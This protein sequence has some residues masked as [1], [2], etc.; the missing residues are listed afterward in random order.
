[1]NTWE[2]YEKGGVM[3]VLIS[4]LSVYVLGVVAY[5][6]WQLVQTNALRTRAVR[7]TL[8]EMRAGR[9]AEAYA[10]L[11]ENGSPLAVVL[12]TVVDC[13]MNRAMTDAQRESEVMRVGAVELARMERHMRGLEM[14]SGI[15]PLLGLLGTVIGLIDSFSKLGASGSRVD[16]AMLA[17]GIWE[18]LLATAAGLA[19]AITAFA[20][21]HVFDTLLDGLRATMQ[22]VTTQAMNMP[23]ADGVVLPK[24]TETSPVKLITPKYVHP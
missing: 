9:V 7:N 11:K 18:A 6:T 20:A 14:A 5:K 17:G 21:H 10:S 4:L 3:V 19:V 2:L 8:A 16:P 15:A 22:D 24:T 13:R 23:L 1:M 12:A